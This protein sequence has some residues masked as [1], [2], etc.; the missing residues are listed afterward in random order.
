MRSWTGI[1]PPHASWRRLF[2]AGL[3]AAVASPVPAGAQ[4]RAESRTG[5]LVI[6]GALGSLVGGTRAVIAGRPVGPALLRGAGGGMLHSIG[7][8]LTTAEVPAAGL[9]ARG[10]SAAGISIIGSAERDT[11]L[12][13]VPLTVLTLY[14]E[15]RPGA[16]VRARINALNTARLAGLV[17]SRDDRLDPGLS[18]ET[19]APVFRH[20]GPI[21]GYNG[22]AQSGIVRIQD[23]L[24]ERIA[25]ESLVPHESIH[26]L[27]EDAWGLL[28]AIPLERALLSQVPR[29]QG[30]LRYFDLGI[31]TDRTWLV[32]NELV[33][34]SRRPWEVEAYF[35]TEGRRWRDR[36]RDSR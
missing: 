17:M 12:L 31:A 10:V 15:P 23:G 19:G 21:D 4:F 3:L 24:P 20:D 6:N 27:Q 33:E 34:Y 18:L 30:V 28:V 2:A 22:F 7:K 35:L 29:T 5:N 9:L 1:R 32:G 8:Q 26:V 11:V 36:H 13:M 14:W 16:R 25:R